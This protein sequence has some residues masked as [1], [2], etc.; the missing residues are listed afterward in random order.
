MFFLLRLPKI[1]GV[2][3]KIAVLFRGLSQMIR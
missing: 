1:I 3:V 2:A